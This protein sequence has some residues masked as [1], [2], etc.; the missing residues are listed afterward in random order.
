MTADTQVLPISSAFLRRRT[1]D[2]DGGDL[3]EGRFVPD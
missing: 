2:A 1:S 3:S